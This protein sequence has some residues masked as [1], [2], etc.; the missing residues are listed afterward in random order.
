[1]KTYK[2]LNVSD[3]EYIQIINT[4]FDNG[5]VVKEHIKG[6]RINMYSDN[7]LIATKCQSA[8][9]EK[10]ELS[11][12]QFNAFIGMF[13]KQL[14]RQFNLSPDLFFLEVD[15]DESSRQ[16]NYD[17]WDKMKDGDF[18]Y[19]V[20]LSSAYWQVAH[21]LGYIGDNIFKKYVSRDEYKQVKRYCISFLGR[22]NKMRYHHKG[23]VFEIECDSDFASRV[24]QNIRY[25]LY[26][27][28]AGGVKLTKNWLEY[29]ID[30]ISVL[31]NEKDIVTDYFKECNLQFKITECRKMNE[32]EYI[33]KNKVR[34][35]KKN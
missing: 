19:N 14:Y 12:A 4:Q 8:E 7:M 30:G 20:D 16:K 29:N 33:Y 13:N 21:K 23:E 27:Y 28:I 9:L 35:F 26:N 32:S 3:S 34:R 1:M 22:K 24:Y 18:F 2:K 15:F 10:G 17:T 31:K 25:A 5:S 11:D 6:S